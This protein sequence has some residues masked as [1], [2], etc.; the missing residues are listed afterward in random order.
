MAPPQWTGPSLR[1]RLFSATLPSDEVELLRCIGL[2]IGVE[3]GESITASMA[4]VGESF[5]E[6]GG[7]G[8]VSE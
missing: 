6:T 2:W 5:G 8:K 3:G 1:N 4:V 7:L